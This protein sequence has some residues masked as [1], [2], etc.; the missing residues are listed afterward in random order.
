MHDHEFAPQMLA[1][2]RT[3]D[4]GQA[5]LLCQVSEAALHDAVRR[6]ET[7]YGQALVRPGTPFQGFTPAGEKVVA[8]FS[9]VSAELDALK[10]GFASAR[11]RTAVE[12][13]LQRRSVSPRRLGW[14]GPQPDDL[15]LMI[16]SALSAPDHGSLHPWRFLTF[17]A[18]HR[19]QLAD[20]F[21]Q[22]KLRRDPL[23]PEGDVQRA[24]EHATRSPVLLAFIVSLRE[25][26][27]VPIRE[28]WLGAGA[29]L[30]NFMNAADRLGFGAIMLSGDRCFDPQLKEALGI[31]S[32]EFLAGFISLGS[33]AEAPPA[34]KPQSLDTVRSVWAPPPAGSSASA[35]AAHPAPF[36][37][38]PIASPR[39]P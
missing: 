9:Q 26:T 12:P 10:R 6:A 24:R 11:K 14:P 38:S 23:A 20:L 30:G 39:I 31:A 21:E 2:H 34:R 3:Q 22:E 18:D 27:Q 8:W 17:E 28:Q 35:K 15:D 7:E 25:R 19:P 4:W 37:S 33:I 16:E 1:L 32:T 13:L 29:A 5:A 36:E